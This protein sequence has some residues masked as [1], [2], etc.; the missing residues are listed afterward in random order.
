MQRSAFVSALTGS[1][2]T[3][4]SYLVV[5]T[6]PSPR[7]TKETL[8]RS[9]TKTRVVL[10]CP[11]LRPPLHRPVDGGDDEATSPAR[12][13]TQSRTASSFPQ[14]RGVSGNAK[15]PSCLEPGSLSSRP[16]ITRQLPVCRCLEETPVAAPNLPQRCLVE[17]AGSFAMHIF[18]SMI[19]VR[20]VRAR[21]SVRLRAVDVAV[22]E[23]VSCDN[24]VTDIAVDTLS[25]VSARA[26]TGRT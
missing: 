14:R 2:S 5:T 22:W 9:I 12:T 17:H 6:S 11:V 7:G 16:H 3:K 19:P 10:S 26:A 4:T 1:F 24:D 18:L 15:P 13:A 23:A 20:T 25:V 8:L 21:R